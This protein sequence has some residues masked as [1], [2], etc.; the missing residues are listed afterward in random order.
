MAESYDVVE[1]FRTVQVYSPTIVIDVE[2]VGFVTKPH[3]VYAVAQVP[4]DAWEAQG[5]ARF[6][7][8]IAN[9]IEGLWRFEG[10]QDAVYVEEVTAAGLLRPEL[11]VVVGI[12][13]PNLALPAPMTGLA[14]IGIYTFLGGEGQAI[15]HSE[16]IAAVRTA[17]LATA[18]L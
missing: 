4:V 12:E 3:G 8:P 16:A 1:Q 6:I 13:S 11:D 7:A 10:V 5:A 18:S 17:L 15:V 2:Q 9:G 14:R